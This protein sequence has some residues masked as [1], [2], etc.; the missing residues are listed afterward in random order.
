[1][2]NVIL[3]GRAATEVEMRYTT[4]GLAVAS[5][6]IAVDRGLSKDKKQEAE[7]KGEQTADF[8]KVTIFNKTAEF[9]G[10]WLKKGKQVAVVG[11]IQ[12]GNYVNNAGVKVYTTEI[13][14]NNVEILEWPDN[15]KAAAG[16]SDSFMA[17]FSDTSED[18]PF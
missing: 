14:G 8:L 9:V 5:F 10:N 7:S 1:M 4:S 6:T 3:I 18:I 17:G 13:I 11:K 15:N 16:P 2:N 12:T